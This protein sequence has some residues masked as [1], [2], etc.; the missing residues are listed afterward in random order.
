VIASDTTSSSWSSC[1]SVVS[2]DEGGLLLSNPWMMT[3]ILSSCRDAMAPK[4]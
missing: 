3:S 4:V 2:E 1:Y